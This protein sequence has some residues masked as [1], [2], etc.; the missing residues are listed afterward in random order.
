MRPLS[1]RGL[2]K[3]EAISF[4]QIASSVTTFPPRNDG[5]RRSC[6]DELRRCKI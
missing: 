5:V 4:E 2:E 6:D 3:A 1:L